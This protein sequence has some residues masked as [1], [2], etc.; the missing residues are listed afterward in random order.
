MTATTCIS[1][2]QLIDDAH[3]EA[4][5]WRDNLALAQRL[6]PALRAPRR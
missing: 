1:A 4:Q 6:L 2:T 3:N 5:A